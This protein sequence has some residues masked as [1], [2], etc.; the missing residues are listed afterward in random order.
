M[1]AYTIYILPQ[2]LETIKVLPG[3]VRQR[4]RREI[5]NL[6]TNPHPS[7]SKR[8]DFSDQERELWRLRLDNWRILYTIDEDGTGLKKDEVYGGA[9]VDS[10]AAGFDVGVGGD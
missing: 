9:G 2:A 7:D 4:V 10:G 5:Q 6:A 3:N 1:T 8:L